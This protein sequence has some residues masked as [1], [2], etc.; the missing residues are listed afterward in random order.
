MLL[1]RD[2][3][4]CAAQTTAERYGARKILERDMTTYGLGTEPWSKHQFIVIDGQPLVYH[5]SLDYLVVR[6]P[7]GASKTLAELREQG[8][9]I[10]IPSHF[11]YEEAAEKKQIPE[12][13]ARHRSKS[14][15]RVRVPKL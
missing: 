14:N 13:R 15:V 3:E 11:R 7:G 2:K 4:H 1:V 9:A 12:L 8:H 6:F 10:H 5:G